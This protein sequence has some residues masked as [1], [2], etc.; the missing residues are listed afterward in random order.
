MNYYCKFLLPF[1]Q[2]FLFP[3]LPSASPLII[4][5]NTTQLCKSAARPFA[6]CDYNYHCKI[7]IC[8]YFRANQNTVASLT[9]WWTPMTH[10]CQNFINLT[11]KTR[12]FHKKMVWTVHNQHIHVYSYIWI[13]MLLPLMGLPVCHFS[14]WSS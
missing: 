12:L 9:M 11:Q 3:L 8:W 10:P 6:I 4:L 7:F 2:F 5:Q 13:I 14:D 1:L